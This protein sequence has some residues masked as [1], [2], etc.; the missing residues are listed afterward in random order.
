MG[1]RLSGLC[2]ALY[3]SKRRQFLGRDGAGCGK[4]LIFNLIK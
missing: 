3:D 4:F 1:G 2:N